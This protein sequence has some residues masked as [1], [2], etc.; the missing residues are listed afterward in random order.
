VRL[1]LEHESSFAVA[2][3][4]HMEVL[5]EPLHGLDRRGKKLRTKQGHER[6]HEITAS[7]PQQL[8]GTRGCP[9]REV[10]AL[11]ACYAKTTLRGI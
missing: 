8:G 7:T 10:F 2:V 4:H 3:H 11:N 1:F 9:R 5:L 6:L